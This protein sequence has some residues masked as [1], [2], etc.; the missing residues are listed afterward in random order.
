MKHLSIAHVASEM[1]PLAKVGG[2]GDVVSAL[3]SEQAKRGH[4]VL[5]VMPRYRDLKIPKGWKLTDWGSTR[6]PWGVGQEPARFQIAEEEGGHLR[7]LLV[8]HAGERRFFDRP[9][10]Y[11]DPNT[12][13]G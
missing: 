13:E 1:A 6:V 10:Y 8:D 12:G 4:R 2:L 9:G 11:D 7:A 5:V 3:A